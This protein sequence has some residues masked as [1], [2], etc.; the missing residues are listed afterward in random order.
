MSG[1]YHEGNGVGESAE[2]IRTQLEHQERNA[3]MLENVR[4]C[5]DGKFL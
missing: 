3:D 4:A 2:D 5:C 1:S